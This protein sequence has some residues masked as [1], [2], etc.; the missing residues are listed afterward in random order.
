M[1]QDLLLDTLEP[2]Q[3][4]HMAVKVLGLISDDDDDLMS[5]PLAAFQRGIAAHAAAPITQALLKFLPQ[6]A[7]R[8]KAISHQEYFA[9]D[10]DLGLS[11]GSTS[12]SYLIT[13]KEGDSRTLLVHTVQS[14]SS[15]EDQ[16]RFR[17]RKDSFVLTFKYTT[18]PDVV[19]D[20]TFSHSGN[21][22]DRG[23]QATLKTSNLGQLFHQLAQDLQ[24]LVESTPD[25]EAHEQN[26]AKVQAEASRRA[27]LTART[28]QEAHRDPRDNPTPCIGRH[29]CAV[30]HLIAKDHHAAMYVLDRPTGL[31]LAL[32]TPDA[33][34]RDLT[35]GRLIR[36]LVPQDFLGER[37]Q[38]RWHQDF[39]LDPPEAL[40]GTWEMILE[41]EGWNDFSPPDSTATASLK[42]IA[43]DLLLLTLEPSQCLHLASRALSLVPTND[44]GL[45]SIPLATIERFVAAHAAAPITRALLNYLPQ[46]SGRMRAV[47]HEHHFVGNPNHASHRSTKTTYL[48]T[49]K[50]GE[51]RTLI[52][53]TVQG[54]FH[55]AS[56]SEMW[57][58]LKFEY[59]AAAEPFTASFSF[60]QV[61]NAQDASDLV[62]TLSSSN[63]QEFLSTLARDLQL[64]LASTPELEAQE[65]SHVED[66]Q[67][68]HRRECD[69]AKAVK[70]A[71]PHQCRGPYSYCDEC[72]RIKQDL[73]NALDLLD[74]PTTLSEELLD[75]ADKRQR[76]VTFGRLIRGLVPLAFRSER[77]WNRFYLEG[78][79]LGLGGINEEMEDLLRGAAASSV[80]LHESQG[81]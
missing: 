14:C 16:G 67:Q 7:G 59:P 33:T 10:D 8:I 42:M 11:H 52:V 31:P 51:R 15:G 80:D 47:S 78:V 39:I 29:S 76:D 53:D 44:E 3:R 35:F 46:L 20:A 64:P 4:T 13:T 57:S 55:G 45:T 27:N 43:Q 73:R 69:E 25:Q 50:D 68:A 66:Q 62:A 6:L 56:D 81:L 63:L 58:H 28:A 18:G 74:R 2:N 65:R 34:Q 79:E 24:I 23:L 12:T 37:T 17:G 71:H 32:R 36:A 54:R 60:T 26:A 70:A 38:T 61:D 21:Y 49:T 40:F 41:A 9:S 22:D 77:P 5:I 1:A 48:I 72:D 30:C 75:S 19:S